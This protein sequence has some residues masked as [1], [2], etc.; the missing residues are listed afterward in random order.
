MKRKLFAWRLARCMLLSLAPIRASAEPALRNG[1]VPVTIIDETTGSEFTQAHG[2]VTLPEYVHYGD[3]VR[4]KYFV[5][6]GDTVTV[7]AEPEE[8]YALGSLR[9]TYKMYA[10]GPDKSLPWDEETGTFTLPARGPVSVTIY[11]SF[12]STYEDYGVT[13]TVLDGGTGNTVTVDKDRADEGE[14]ITVT[15]TMNPGTRSMMQITPNDAMEADRLFTLLMGDDVEP[16][17]LFIQ[18]NSDLV[19]DLDV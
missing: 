19:K 14:L 17:K 18:E 4:E 2:K 15:V 5:S 8:G 9:V 10:N 7:L 13:V 6:R 1:S 11:V 12:V 16:R 3:Y